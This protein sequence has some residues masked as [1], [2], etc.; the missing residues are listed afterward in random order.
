MSLLPFG[1]VSEDRGPILPAFRPLLT[2]ATPFRVL[3]F[4]LSGQPTLAQMEQETRDR[5]GLQGRKFSKTEANYAPLA[6]VPP[7]GWRYEC[8]RCIFFNSRDK[9]CQVMGLP[10]D[11]FGGES[12]HPIA[13]CSLW[14]PLENQPL[15][16]WAAEFVDPSLIPREV[17]T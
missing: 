12:V 14:L 17:G 9:T 16:R 13:W 8:G 5:V 1:T 11:G 10:D 7:L 3:S 4:L 15:L 6:P 2:L